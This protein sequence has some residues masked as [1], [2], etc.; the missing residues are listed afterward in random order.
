MPSFMNWPSFEHLLK[1]VHRRQSTGV[2][3]LVGSANWDENACPFSDAGM[4]LKP[5][6][7]YSVAIGSPSRV[8]PRT[9]TRL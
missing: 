5:T 9:S 6:L 3:T 7:R 8:L 4:S 1:D 2:Q